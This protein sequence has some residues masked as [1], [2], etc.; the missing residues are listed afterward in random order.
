MKTII[1]ALGQAI[2]GEAA[3]GFMSPEFK[4]IM[5]TI[6]QI[7]VPAVADTPEGKQALSQIGLETI[8]LLLNHLSGSMV[9]ERTL[10]IMRDSGGDLC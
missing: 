9:T 4:T 2:N 10:A 1:T 6:G 5:A 8:K 3:P 7:S